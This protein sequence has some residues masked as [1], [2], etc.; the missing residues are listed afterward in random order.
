M[1]P[2]TSPSAPA[3]ALPSSRRAYALLLAL[4]LVSLLTAF[5]TEG[6]YD[7][8]D[9]INHYLYARYAFQHPINF[10]ESWSKPLVV[11]LMAVPAQAGLRGVMVLQCLLVAASA[12]FAYG[13]ARALRLPWPWLAIL[14][15]YA[16]PITSAFNFRG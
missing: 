8:G 2:S 16:S 13:A 12:W 7:S 4:L 15:C 3:V 6:T 11:E 9:S 14:F 5:I 10:L 1:L